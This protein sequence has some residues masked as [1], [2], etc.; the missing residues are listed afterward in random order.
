MTAGWHALATAPA[1]RF[2]AAALAAWLDLVGNP[3]A[4]IRLKGD[5]F[6]TRDWAAD[7]LCDLFDLDAAHHCFHSSPHTWARFH[8]PQMTR[9]LAHFLSAGDPARRRARCVAFVKA[10]AL[11]AGVKAGPFEHV[12]TATAV[13]EENRTDLLVTLR[14]GGRPFGASIEAKF[15]HA[16]TPGQLQKAR[17]HVD[18]LEWD[19]DASVLLVVAPEARKLPARLKRWRSTC[20][21]SLLSQFERQ[22]ASAHDCEEFRRFRRTIWHR[23]Y[24]EDGHA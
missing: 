18:G 8:E 4:T 14:N 17:E 12:S 3:D 9:G 22:L 10:A 6:P 20:W 24:Q 1:P 2:D 11:C 21:W 13:A 19:P 16:L 15:G 7:G 5:S 23:A